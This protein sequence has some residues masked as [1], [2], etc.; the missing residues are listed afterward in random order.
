LIP[1]FDT[2]WFDGDIWLTGDL[3]LGHRNILEYEKRPWD[4]I[5]RHD[6]MLISIAREVVKPNDL[7]IIVGDLALP[8]RDTHTRVMRYRTHRK[9]PYLSMGI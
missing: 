2:S 6:N 5:D 1:L 4:N 7:Y 9:T 8:G 3:H